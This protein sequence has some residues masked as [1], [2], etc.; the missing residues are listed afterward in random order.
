MTAIA[1]GLKNTK[2]LPDLT[3]LLNNYPVALKPTIKE[4]DMIKECAL[5][6]RNDGIISMVTISGGIRPSIDL[7]WLNAGDVSYL[8][9]FV[10]DSR[11]EKSTLFWKLPINKWEMPNSYGII[12]KSCESNDHKNIGC[13]VNISIVGLY[14][15]KTS[16]SQFKGKRFSL[17][18]PPFIISEPVMTDGVDMKMRIDTTS[19]FWMDSLL[20]IRN[21][22]LKN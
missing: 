1:E 2:D 12:E 9:K 17:I 15:L 21:R 4:F 16:N 11:P 10:L 8:K 20:Q 3:Y 7:E 5:I 6:Q 14:D 18:Q 19:F 22:I 13:S